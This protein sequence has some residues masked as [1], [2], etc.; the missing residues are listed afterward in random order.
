VKKISILK[1]DWLRDR[2]DELSRRGVSKADIARKLDVMPQYLNGLLNSDRGITDQFLDKFI[3]VFEIA[4]FDLLPRGTGERDERPEPAP[5]APIAPTA[6][7]DA[8]HDPVYKGL[9]AEV[10]AEHKQQI[11]E[12]R[13]EHRQEIAAKDREINELN[14]KLGAVEARLGERHHTASSEFSGGLSEVL[15]PAGRHVESP[16]KVSTTLVERHEGRRPTSK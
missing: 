16:S 3:E 4:H 13:V 14:R 8:G 2:I 12:M 1:K 11:A 7:S 6:P 5:I 9:L 10:K 15:I